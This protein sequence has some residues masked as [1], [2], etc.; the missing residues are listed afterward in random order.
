[1]GRIAAANKRG[2]VIESNVGNFVQEF[3]WR[4]TRQNSPNNL[5]QSLI[6]IITNNYALI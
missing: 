5:L 2:G 6:N 4:R 3:L 1:L